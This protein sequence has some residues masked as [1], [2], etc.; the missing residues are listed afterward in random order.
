MKKGSNHG[1]DKEKKEKFDKEKRTVEIELQK[2]VGLVVYRK[3]STDICYSKAYQFR[4]VLI[5]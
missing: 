4:R 3:L 1:K 5:G 2:K